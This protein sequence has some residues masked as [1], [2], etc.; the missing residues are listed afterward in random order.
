[1]KI[2]LN[3]ND[4]LFS[5]FYADCGT[6]NM[7]AGI[8]FKIGHLFENLPATVPGG[9]QVDLFNNGLIE[10]PF[11][12]HNALLCE[13]AQHKNW[14]YVKKFS[15]P[16]ETLGRKARLEFAGVNFE[17]N[18]YLNGRKLGNH[19]N[20]HTPAVFDVTNDLKEENELTVLLENIPEDETQIGRGTK[21]KNQDQRFAYA[22]D[23]CASMIAVGI[24][25]GVE[26][27]ISE[28]YEITDLFAQTDVIDGKG[29]LNLA[30]STDTFE[31][32]RA[33]ISLE[34]D[35][36]T[37]YEGETTVYKN[38]NLNV[39]LD[40]VQLWYPNTYGEQALYNLSVRLLDGEMV[41]DERTVAIGF[42]SLAY[43]KNE[44]A[45]DD[46]LPYTIVVNGKK[47]YAKGTIFLPYDQL[48]GRINK[49]GYDEW[50][51]MIKAANIN[52]IRLWGGGVFETDYFYQLC[53]KYGVM[54]WQDFM[55]SSS[56]LEGIPSVEPEFLE[57]LTKSSVHILKTVRNHVCNVM[58][59]G[60]NELTSNTS[61]KRKVPVGY[62]QK[63]IALLKGLVETYDP[64]KQFIPTTPCGPN[65]DNQLDEESILNKTNHNV[66]GPWYYMGTTQHYSD[67]NRSRC[68]YHG[69][70]GSDGMLS[71]SSMKKFL[72]PKTAK[73]TDLAWRIHG[74]WWWETIKR[75]VEVFGEKAND[76]RLEIHASQLLQ[77]E[78]LRY[79]IAR[80]RGRAFYCS[81]SNI[82]QF[83]EPWPNVCC[84][85]LVDYYRTPK[86]AYYT[87]KKAYA[88]V[89][90]NLK[91]DSVCVKKG[92]E[93]KAELHVSNLGSETYL[94]PVKVEIIA[95]DKVVDSR[96]Y[97]S[98]VAE[99]TD[100]KLADI[101][102]TPDTDGV[103]FIR[104]TY[105]NTVENYC[106]GTSETCVFAPLLE[107]KDVQIE[108]SYE[109]GEL[110]V[111]N[112][113]ENG[114]Y[115]LALEEIEHTGELILEDNY[116]CL[117]SGESRTLKCKGYRDGNLKIENFTKG[118]NED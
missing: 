54:V 35:G 96:I 106:F 21:C 82:W 109:N 20:V 39:S 2:C 15:L 57:E 68:Q 42:R 83:N 56:G 102:Y 86:M 22:W 58:Y 50:F 72:D 95:N 117:L 4:W 101:S 63:N 98:V 40:N 32:V 84:S 88:P 71:Y 51:S 108:L 81:G 14:K 3:G 36:K 12:G 112:V 93:L 29:V 28:K 5:C 69:E 53:D 26:L 23:F 47:I 61:L 27:V 6:F 104:L 90:A 45:P 18:F 8:D 24:F 89:F 7:E 17:A 100:K 60:G 59:C 33:Q 31:G 34:K 103:F 38:G 94:D 70:V 113:G 52:L 44:G 97:E 91:Y 10:D 67:N 73:R 74:N 77:A 19:K 118:G 78:G 99:N 92:S 66:H 30:L 87:L 48:L 9:V 43:E 41:T 55:Q 115:F 64:R 80:S 75:D 46:S 65:F 111:K 1:M 76:I 25:R 13:W 11:V 85:S 62:D 110:T 79:I 107:E 105:G 37:V 16:K 49:A 116:L 114:A